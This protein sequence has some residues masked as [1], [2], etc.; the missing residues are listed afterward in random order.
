MSHLFY[1]YTGYVIPF[2]Q[3]S[4]NTMLPLFR[5]YND[6]KP[7]FMFDVLTD[8]CRNPFQFCNV[9]FLVKSAIF[10]IK[11]PVMRTIHLTSS[12][13]HSLTFIDFSSGPTNIQFML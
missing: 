3:V 2:V 5:R 1:T 7:Y 4:V 12:I 10:M 6:T 8:V 9:V 13:F 11:T